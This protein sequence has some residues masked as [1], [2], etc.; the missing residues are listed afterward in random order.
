MT[1]TGD[2]DGDGRMDLLVG[3]PEESVGSIG[4]AGLVHVIYGSGRWSNNDGFIRIR[5]GGRVL[6]NQEIGLV[7]RSRQVISTMTGM[8]TWWSVF[9]KGLGGSNQLVDAG[10]ITIAYGSASGLTSPVICIST[11][12]VWEPIQNQGT[13]SELL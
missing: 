13:F 7:Q 1:D 2:F 3:A 5:L 9:P 11:V 10:M 4:D 8:T 12:P 6:Q